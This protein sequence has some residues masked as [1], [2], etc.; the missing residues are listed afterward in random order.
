MFGLLLHLDLNS[1]QMDDAFRSLGNNLEVDLKLDLKDSRVG[2]E[3][4]C[5][6]VLGEVS[7]EEILIGYGIWYID[8]NS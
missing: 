6:S 7:L 4:H 1:I 5:N 3:F 2:G 8:P